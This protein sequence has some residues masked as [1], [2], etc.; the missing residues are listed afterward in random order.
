MN[1]TF[2]ELEDTITHLIEDIQVK[3]LKVI[4]IEGV[5]SIQKNFEVGGRPKWIPS[6]K[7]G[8]AKGT[9]TL[10]ITGALSSITAVADF[11]SHRVTFHPGPGA[12]AYARIHQEGGIINRK[13]STSARRT[14]RDGRSV[15][16][17]KRR[18]TGRAKKVDVSFSKAYSIVIPARPYMVIPPEDIPVMINAITRAIQLR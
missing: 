18:D 4:E 14:K 15:F 11:N 6:Q 16:A 5:R 13:A 2:K 8:K 9:N 1:K 10:R 17:S 12:R 3:A 7:K